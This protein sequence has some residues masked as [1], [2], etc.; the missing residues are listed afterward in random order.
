[1]GA[2]KLLLIPPLVLLF[3][4]W[5]FVL[6][7]CVEIFICLSDYNFNAFWGITFTITLLFSI[8]RSE[9]EFRALFQEQIGE[10]SKIAKRL[11]QDFEALVNYCLSKTGS[12]I[13][14]EWIFST[15]GQEEQDAKQ[16]IE[17]S[18]IPESD[19][20]DI[21]DG[22]QAKRNWATALKEIANNLNIEFDFL[23]LFQKKFSSSFKPTLGKIPIY[24][25]NVKDGVVPLENVIDVLRSSADH[26]SNFFHLFYKPKGAIDG[27]MK[28]KIV[29]SIAEMLIV[30]AN[31]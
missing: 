18:D 20:K 27:E 4:F 21:M 25:P 1:M 17:N 14:G 5:L 11:E 8:Y 6:L 24:F 13:V 15:L 2:G 31:Y 3:L 30:K 22:I 29:Q 23:I 7:P 9:A 12:P 16:A 10:G 28:A 19:Y 26:K